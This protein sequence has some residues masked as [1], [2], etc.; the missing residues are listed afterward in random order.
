[1]ISM[2]SRSNDLRY[3]T[4]WQ[5]TPGYLENEILDRSGVRVQASFFVIALCMPE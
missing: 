1:M 4:M 2:L 3:E 5:N